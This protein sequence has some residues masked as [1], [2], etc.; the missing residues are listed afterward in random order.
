VTITAAADGSA[1]G[2]PGPAGWAWYVDD[3]H[4][5]AGG[6][7]HATNN[8]G[9]LKAVLELF[10]ATAHLDDDLLVLCDSQYVIKGDGKPVLN[11]ELLKE[12]DAEIQ[13]RR[14]RF[15][16][17]KGHANHP[18][19]EAADDRARAVATAFQGR[20]PI[21]EG[22]GWAGHE[23]VGS[24]ARA[25]EETAA[26]EADAE[27]AADPALVEAEAVEA[28]APAQPGLFD[29]DA[30]DEEVAPEP[31]DTTLTIALDRDAMARLSALARD[32]GLSV[33]EAV[34]ELLP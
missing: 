26:V 31:G 13:G 8:Q 24:A 3:E 17:V 15:E 20:R 33:D 10:R 12:I 4:W 2:N 21:P 19:N 32:R 22:P 34:R 11:V 25:T 6:W 9:E 16:W 5:A 29:F 18:L 23:T 30:F 1:L 14:Y 7:P 27:L 28:E